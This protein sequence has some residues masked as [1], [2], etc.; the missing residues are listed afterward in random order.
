M[1]LFDILALLI[2][3]TACFSWLNERFLKLPGAIGSML[4][5]MVFSLLLL[6]PL[7]L[8]TSFEHEV[9]RMLAGIDLGETLLHGMLGFL[10]FAGALHV[11]LRALAE[12]KWVVGILA[13]AS[14][15][16]ATLLIGCGLYLLLWLLGL[17]VPLLYCLIFGALISPTDP[18]A[19]LGILKSAKAPKALEMKITGE[20]LFNDGIA[21]VLFMVLL[22]LATGESNPGVIDTL[23]LLLT[24]ILG[25]LLF[26]LA[27]GWIALLMIRGTRSYQVEIMITLA[28]AMSGYA[29]A[30]HAQVSA[31]IA[32]VVAGLLIGNRGQAAL[33]PQTRYRLDDFWE[34]IDEILNGVLF[35]L[36]GLEL[37]VV[38]ITGDFMLAGLLVI[39]MV[40]L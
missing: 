26:G 27:L 11:D 24:E 32:I 29:I 34:L 18:I 35:V 19:V 37:L 21:V 23:R 14:V 5:A 12:Q 7:P 25:G 22:G 10:L 20:S 3:F 16:G 8:L 4:I 17:E 6:L 31:P 39:E 38:S 33:T 9:E 15:L 30:E 13:S 2:G 28:L 40:L 36:I 1:R